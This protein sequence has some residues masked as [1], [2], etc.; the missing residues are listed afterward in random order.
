MG[1]FFRGAPAPRTQER[2]AMDVALPDGS[3]ASV[4]RV[5]DPR[6]RRIKLL[7]SENGARLTV[8]LRAS[9]READRFLALHLDWLATQLGKRALPVDVPVFAVGDATPLKLRG[10]NLP[11]TWTPGRLLRVERDILGLR[12]THPDHVKIASLRRA[13]REFYL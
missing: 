5:R 6:A 9:L 12:I 1:G 4:L 7:V 11:V 10:E 3:I 8:P 13:L 2:E